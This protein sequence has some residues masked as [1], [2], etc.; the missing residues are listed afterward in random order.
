MK[1]IVYDDI[2]KNIYFTSNER[3]DC[4]NFINLNQ[5]DSS[6]DHLWI[7]EINGEEN[8]INFINIKNK[9]KIENSKHIEA[10]KMIEYAMN[11]KSDLYYSL[12]NDE[13][14]EIGKRDIDV[15]IWL[16]EQAKI[17]EMYKATLI[18][19]ASKRH[20][21]PSLLASLV[22]FEALERFKNK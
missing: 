19:I 11:L 2:N 20:D 4:L 15:I 17:S 3:N 21:N 8:D 13:E 5:N 22:L 18:D 9:E 6:W 16:I 7:G 14:Q 10:S 12:M 1:F